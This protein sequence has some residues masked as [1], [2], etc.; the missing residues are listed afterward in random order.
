V[1]CGCGASCGSIGVEWFGNAADRS[2]GIENHHRQHTH[3]HTHGTQV[4]K[5][6][7]ARSLMWINWSRMVRQCGGPQLRYRESS[8]ATHT[9]TRKVGGENDSAVTGD[10]IDTQDAA[11]RL[12]STS[13]PCSDQGYRTRMLT[14]ANVGFVP[15]PNTGAWVPSDEG[16]LSV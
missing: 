13:F 8:P 4:Q 16:S 5:S 12:Y 11:S 10:M 15:H 14:L 2:Y 1:G 3:T 6:C 7:S 9:H